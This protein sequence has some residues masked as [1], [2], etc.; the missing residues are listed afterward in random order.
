MLTSLS[1]PDDV[2]DRDAA[3]RFLSS[4]IDYERALAVPYGDRGFKLDRMRE[5][6]RRLGNPERGMPL[7]HVAGSKGKGSTATMIGSILTASGRRTG[8]F[9]SPHM[10][11]VEQRIA[12]DREPCS[13]RELVELVEAIQPAV[14]AMDAR[15]CQHDAPSESQP[16]YFEITT[17]MAMV[18][19]L[20]KKADVA[21]LEVGLGGRLDSTNV[22]QPLVSVITSISF[23]H[24][25]QLGNTLS[26]IAREKA[27]IIKPG[28]PVVS[29]VVEAEPRDTIRE[30]CRRL[31]SPLFEL[32]TDFDFTYH[33]PIGADTTELTPSIDF[34]DRSGASYRGLK[35]GMLGRH[36]GTNAAVALAT[37]EIL[38]KSG[39]FVSE[40]AVR[41]GLAQA[42]CPARVEIVARDPLVVIDAAHNRASVEALVAVLDE[43]FA[44]RRR[45]LIFGTTQE[46][47]LRGMLEVLIPAFDRVILTRYADNPRA[48]EPETLAAVA[49]QL[50]GRCPPI[51]ATSE[52][53]WNEAQGHATADELIC[54]TGSFY[55]AAEIRRQV[56]GTPPRRSHDGP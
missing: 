21:I 14:A 35:L 19:F 12:V 44:G 42:V 36:Q 4:R 26:A 53:A 16:T 47:D 27:G 6:L 11:R 7:V 31:N 56:G 33:S 10:D 49:E 34:V 5:L 25:R 17:A 23:D 24:T 2:L 48:V 38:K 3:V 39:W 29:G 51:I 40:E 52:A 1:T 8:L 32:H 15:V 22:C 18:H 9:T 30:V 28:I 43:S 45:C 13:P 54:V 37:V 41:E 55:L 50:T 46:K 20:R